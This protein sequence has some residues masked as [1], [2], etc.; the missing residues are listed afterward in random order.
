[1]LVHES[2]Q[3]SCRLCDFKT[4]RNVSLKA[5][6]KSNHFGL[7][8]LCTLCESKYSLPKVIYKDT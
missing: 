2:Q 3:F 7:K 6:I 8:L 1:M 4:T 5:H